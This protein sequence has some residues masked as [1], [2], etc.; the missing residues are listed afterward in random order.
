MVSSISQIG[1]RIMDFKKD[2]KEKEKEFEVFILDRLF[3][4]IPEE[5]EDLG[6]PIEVKIIETTTRKGWGPMH[7][8]TSP[9]GFSDLVSAPIN[10]VEILVKITARELQT[11]S[12]FKK[13]M[14][15]PS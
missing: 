13:S 14:G 9:S 6:R 10:E 8:H 15:L 1:S 2:R 11:S 4:E 7:S 12:E 3:G 5:T